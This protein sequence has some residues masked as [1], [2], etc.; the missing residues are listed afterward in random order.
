VLVFFLCCLI[1]LSLSQPWVS[2]SVPSSS[3]SCWKGRGER[4]A[5]RCGVAGCRVKLQHP[6]FPS[7][8]SKPHT[9][10][11][12]SYFLCNRAWAALFSAAAYFPA[13]R[14]CTV[15]VTQ[16][17]T[18]TASPPKTLPP[19][20]T[21]GTDSVSFSAFAPTPTLHYSNHKHVKEQVFS[22]WTSQNT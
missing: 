8:E 6:A 7:A 19:V 2:A 4:A 20:Q 9:G 18:C 3:P 15:H 17:R 10:F 11:P 21:R 16:A 13:H 5:V 22:P 14:A 1:K 12:H